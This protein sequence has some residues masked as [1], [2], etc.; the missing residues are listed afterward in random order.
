[1][2]AGEIIMLTLKMIIRTIV[3]Y[4][5]FRYGVVYLFRRIINS[6]GK[7][8]FNFSKN[9]FTVFFIV[10]IIIMVIL[11]IGYIVIFIKSKGK[12][13]DL[14]VIAV[15]LFGAILGLIKAVRVINNTN[16]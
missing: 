4:S 5:F 1:M 10:F 11:L 6:S 16:R 15:P 7:M 8:P 9:F 12:F 13:S 2:K 14:A 3:F